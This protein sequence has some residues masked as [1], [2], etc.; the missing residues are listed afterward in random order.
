MFSNSH[1]ARIVVVDQSRN[2]FQTF[3]KSLCVCA[4]GEFASRRLSPNSYWDQSENTMRLTTNLEMFRPQFRFWK[5][6]ENKV[7]PHYNRAFCTFC[8]RNVPGVC[9]QRDNRL[10]TTTAV[11]YGSPIRAV[12]RKHETRSIH[13][14]NDGY[15]N[16]QSMARLIRVCTSEIGRRA[17]FRAED[18]ALTVG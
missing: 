2:Q 13:G 6:T 4:T 3:P 18:R 10:F 17:V 8:V 12:R 15:R 16:H 11:G 1:I 14:L 9:H 7:V 5:F